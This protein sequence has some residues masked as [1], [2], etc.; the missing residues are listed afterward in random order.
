MRESSSSVSRMCERNR[1]PR[2]TCESP[3]RASHIQKRE[4]AF[5]HGHKFHPKPI[6]VAGSVQRMLPSQGDRDTTE[7]C[8]GQEEHPHCNL[9][10][11]KRLHC[12]GEEFSSPSLMRSSSLVR[13]GS[14]GRRLRRSFW[15]FEGF[16]VRVVGRG[17]IARA[18]GPIGNGGIEIR[19][20]HPIH[21]VQQRK[22]RFD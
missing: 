3:S 22:R 4:L 8:N 15:S 7:G 2:Q 12:F 5:P 19:K 18:P 1:F 6:G 11:G 16:L 20:P 14:L 10:F 13:S 21:I 9:F 17:G